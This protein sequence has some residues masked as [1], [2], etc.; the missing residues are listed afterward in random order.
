MY[1]GPKAGC[2]GL[3]CPVAL[4]TR[5]RLR[6]RDHLERAL[7]KLAE[8]DYGLYDA[9]GPAEGRY[10]LVSPKHLNA[11][12][13]GFIK[14]DPKGLSDAFW[15]VL[16]GSIHHGDHRGAQAG[17]GLRI[18]AGLDEFGRLHSQLGGPVL[19][20]IENLSSPLLDMV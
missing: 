16:P 12:A 14:G 20:V 15:I 2:D 5:Q 10:P 4:P 9:G 7:V 18:R 1:R 19:S 17:H 11:F 3:G 8:P 13:H 6:H